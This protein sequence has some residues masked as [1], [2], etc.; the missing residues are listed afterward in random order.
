ME[1]R[2][3]KSIISFIFLLA[4][5]VMFA[6]PAQAVDDGAVDLTRSGSISVTLQDNVNQAL[7][8]GAEFTLYRVAD[9][10]DSGY[11]LAYTFT[12]DFINCGVSLDNLSKDGLPAHFSAY[13]DS[14]G[15]SGVV[16]ETTGTNGLAVFMNLKTGLYLVRQTKAASG[17]YPASP[18]LVSVPMTINSEWIYD[19]KAS[20]KAEATAE[21][22]ETQLTVNKVWISKGANIP[23]SVT[24]AL[25]RDG[26]T[27][28]TEVL[29]RAN[30]WIF[31]WKE[32]DAA[33]TWSAVE[34]NVPDGYTASYSSSSSVITITNTS[35]NATPQGSTPTHTTTLILTGQL[36]WPIPIL[37]GF[38]VLLIT[39]GGALVLVKKKSRHD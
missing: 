8:P 19:V 1:K 27:Y 21:S 16:C 35:T 37:V 9:A 3:T 22:K 15:L 36:N 23:D 38:G 12:A 18:F 10:Y 34:L 4:I 31:T 25:L 7:L 5:T 29:N 32:L 30:N 28:K 11:N 20:P 26:T 14:H 6:C 13:A 24:V 2:N 33:H 39:I 17:Y